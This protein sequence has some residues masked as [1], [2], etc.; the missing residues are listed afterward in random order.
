MNNIIYLD[1]QSTT[2]IDPEVL[3]SIDPYLNQLFGNPASINHILGWQAEE[4]VEIA[5]EYVS[6]SIG[7]QSNEIIFTS[8]ATESINIALKGLVGTYIK[9]GD[10][11][12]TTNIEHKAVIDVRNF[13]S[14]QNLEQIKQCTDDEFVYTWADLNQSFFG[15]SLLLKRVDKG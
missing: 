14:K 9:S 13:I 2:P 5:R 10:H 12:I 1:N 6:S 3:K 7:A 11:I 8:G 15:A 4:A